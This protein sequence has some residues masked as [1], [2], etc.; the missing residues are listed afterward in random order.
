[1]IILHH[2][3]SR[4]IACDSAI[5]G[6]R[7]RHATPRHAVCGKQHGAQGHLPFFPLHE[8]ALILFGMFNIWIPTPAF[9]AGGPITLH[10]ANCDRSD[11]RHPTESK[12]SLIYAT[13]ATENVFKSHKI[14]LDRNG[15]E[16]E[17]DGVEDDKKLWLP[18][19]KR[20]QNP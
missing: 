12:R 1:M 5:A 14:N 17:E 8:L 10:S 4:I 19:K 6:D 13:V 2:E 11:V 18:P 15:K 9:S 3:R 7:P 16:E 20:I